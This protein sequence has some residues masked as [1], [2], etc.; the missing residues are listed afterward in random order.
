MPDDYHLQPTKVD[1]PDELLHVQSVDW[2]ADNLPS[3]LMD[4][5]GAVDKAATP[6]SP[7]SY[8]RSSA[9]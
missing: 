4:S 2:Q 7:S 8:P 9:D 5:R 6:K 1:I 3:P